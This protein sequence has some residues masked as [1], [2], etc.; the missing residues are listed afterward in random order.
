MNSRYVLA[1]VLLLSAPLALNAQSKDPVVS[2]EVRKT[3]DSFVGHWRLTGTDL[4]PNSKAAQLTVGMDCEPAALSRAVRCRVVSDGPGGEHSEMASLIGYSEDEGVVRLM[5]V[6]SSGANHVH[7]GPWIGNI[8]QFEKLAYSEAG[9]KRVEMF[10]IGF[11][12]R[13]K[14]TVKS[15]TETAEGKAI[16]DLAGTRRPPR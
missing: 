12:S 11:P 16:L 6:S 7:T 10:S 3:V 14:I 5:E 13:G 9:S 15:V 2:P 1:V 4:E 8:I